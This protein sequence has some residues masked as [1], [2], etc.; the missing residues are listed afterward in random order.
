VGGTREPR[1]AGIGTRGNAPLDHRQHHVVVDPGVVTGEVPE[2]GGDALAH[3]DREHRWMTDDPTHHAAILEDGGDPVHQGETHLLDLSVGGAVL[4]PLQGGLDRSRRH[5]VARVRTGLGDATACPSFHHLL[6]QG[7]GRHREA[8]AHRLGVGG[9]IGDHTERSDGA[10]DAEPEPGLD[11]V[12]DQHHFVLVAQ[13]TNR[14]EETGLG[15]DAEEVARHRF[16]DHRCQFVAVVVEEF[17]EQLDVVVR[18][19]PDVAPDPVGD[20]RR[21]LDWERAKPG[22]EV[23]GRGTRRGEEH[24]VVGSVI[25]TLELEDE[26]TRPPSSRQPNRMHGRLGAGV[27]EPEGSRPA[28]HLDHLLGRLDLDALG[29]GEHGAGRCRPRNRLGDVGV[30]VTQDHRA[31]TELEVDVILAVHVDDV[32]GVAVIH[33]QRVVIAPVA[34]AARHPVDQHLSRPLEPLGGFRTLDT[35]MHSLGTLFRLPSRE[36]GRSGRVPVTECERVSK[37][38]RRDDG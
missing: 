18:Q 8:V 22:A 9:D 27:G 30:S 14:L 1:L 19:G 4:Q 29:H 13:A 38:V 10:V 31:E 33:H 24:V 34:E 11:L 37:V 12:E 21:G 15:K 17:A 23:G 26:V 5:R 25:G 7:D 28:E 35:H 3:E 32:A 36:K 20:A 6:G 2:L 16:H